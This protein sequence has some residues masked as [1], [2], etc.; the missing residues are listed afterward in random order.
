MPTRADINICIGL[1]IETSSRSH[2]QNR[3]SDWFCSGACMC[4]CVNLLQA[5]LLL[6]PFVSGGLEGLHAAPHVPLENLAVLPLLLPQRH[7]V[8]AV[9]GLVLEN[10]HTH[11]VCH[12]Q[13]HGGPLLQALLL[14]TRLLGL[15]RF[16][17]RT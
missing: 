2:V 12:Q 11:T 10:T 9:V 14:F 4:T 16:P 1:D 7:E 6:V 13:L 15:Y 17:A 5:A 3:T 8:S